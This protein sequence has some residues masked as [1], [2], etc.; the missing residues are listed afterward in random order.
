MSLLSYVLV[1]VLFYSLILYHTDMILTPASPAHLFTDP[2]H[3]PPSTRRCVPL[4]LLLPRRESARDGSRV[5]SAARRF[6]GQQRRPGGSRQEPGWVA[7]DVDHA[8]GRVLPSPVHVGRTRRGSRL[9]RSPNSH[10]RRVR[11]L[12]SEVSVRWTGRL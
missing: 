2:V 4:P 12:I 1:P 9:W 6:H 11:I 3:V 7:Y 10:I 5:R 8:R